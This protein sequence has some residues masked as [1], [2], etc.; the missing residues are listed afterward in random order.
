MLWVVI[1]AGYIL[2]GPL[3]RGALQFNQRERMAVAR[4]DGISG[5]VPPDTRLKIGPCRRLS[6]RTKGHGD[7]LPIRSQSLRGTNEQLGQGPA[8]P[9]L[10]AL[11]QPPCWPRRDIGGAQLG[12]RIPAADTD[13]SNRKYNFGKLSQTVL[14]Y[15]D[16]AGR[17]RRIWAEAR[18]LSRDE[19][20]S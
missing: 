10:N 11:T 12:E 15:L 4:R 3:N 5:I 8:G 7:P 16:I 17:R 20:V 6:P 9:P 1:L 18:S 19:K 2:D 14:D 13:L